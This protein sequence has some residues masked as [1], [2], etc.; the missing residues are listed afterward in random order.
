[1]YGVDGDRV[2]QNG[3]LFDLIWLV[4]EVQMRRIRVLV[5][6][7]ELQING[8][9]VLRNEYVRFRNIDLQ[10]MLLLFLHPLLRLG[11]SNRISLLIR[12][13]RHLEHLRLHR[14]NDRRT[15]RVQLGLVRFGMFGGNRVRVVPILSD[16]KSKRL[17]VLLLLLVKHGGGGRNF[18][19]GVEGG[20]VLDEV[21]LGV[22]NH[23]QISE[24]FG[25]KSSQVLLFLK[26]AILF[27]GPFG[28]D[29][30]GGALV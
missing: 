11:V 7:V 29:G 14:K 4:L 30:H 8:F 13:N 19:R 23:F 10:K 27:V 2:K 21:L 18:D 22:R 1:M 6:L 15:G 28:G 12:R 25:L 26:F 20:V 5:E 3:A 24:V 17:R 16:L 9:L